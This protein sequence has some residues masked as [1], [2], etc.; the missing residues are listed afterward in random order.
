MAAGLSDIA[1]YIYWRCDGSTVIIRISVPNDK[2]VLHGNVLDD[3]F[4]VVTGDEADNVE[5]LTT[6]TLHGGRVA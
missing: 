4:T 1:L 6:I 5:T 3:M 2:N